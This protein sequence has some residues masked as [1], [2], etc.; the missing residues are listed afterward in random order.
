V[1]R[2]DC[3]SRSDSCSS[4]F[5]PSPPPFLRRRSGAGMHDNQLVLLASGW[6][7]AAGT[8][9]MAFDVVNQGA[10][11]RIGGYPTSLSST[12]A[13]SQSTVMMSTSRRCS[14]RAENGNADPGARGVATFGVSWATI[15]SA[16][17]LAQRRPAL[18]S[19]CAREWQPLGRSADQSEPCGE[20]LWLRQ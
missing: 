10:R 3:F 9:A 11:C 12:R 16:I 18:W 5:R 6:F 19:N 1:L 13:P 17:R 20:P 8:G 4:A 14:S 15:Q 7:G 2:L